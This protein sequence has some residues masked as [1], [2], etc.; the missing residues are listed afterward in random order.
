[1]RTSCLFYFYFHEFHCTST[2]TRSQRQFS[3]L[4]LKL[5]ALY[6]IQIWE[7]MK[8]KWRKRIRVNIILLNTN[9]QGMNEW[10]NMPNHHLFYLLCCSVDHNCSCWHRSRIDR[11][12]SSCVC[13]ALL[14]SPLLDA[15]L[16]LTN[17][18]TTENTSLLTWNHNNSVSCTGKCL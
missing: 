8:E 2:H 17:P 7:E 9:W 16:T 15:S 5:V 14:R 12:W 18:N 13:G 4:Q 11:T 1:L 3:K 6:I 10:M